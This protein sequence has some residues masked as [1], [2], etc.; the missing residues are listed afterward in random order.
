MESVYL[1]RYTYGKNA[2][3]AF[4]SIMHAYG[5]SCGVFYGEKAW[6]AAGKSVRDALHQAG[7]SIACSGLYGHEASMEN[8]ENIIRQCQESKP[9]FLIAAGGGKCVD[10]VKYAAEKLHLPLFTCPTIGSN[11]APVTKIAIM[12]HMD[13]SFREITQLSSPPVHCFINTEIICNA[14][15]EYLQAGIGDTMAK[16]V[17]AVFSARGD[18]LSYPVALGI[19]ISGLCWEGMLKDGYRAYEDARKHVLS[20]ELERV[21]QN[22]IITTGA[23]S[24]TVGKDYNSALAHALYYGLTVR[25]DVAEKYLHGAIVSYGTLIQLMLDHQMED[26]AKAWRFNQSM[27]LPVRLSDLGLSVDSD[28]SD[29]LHVTEINQEL[30]HVPYNID[31]HMILDAMKKLENWQPEEEEN[32]K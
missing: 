7:I 5:N 1:P 21:I 8:A 16:H 27:H 9:D 15:S 11:C 18:T 26:L 25:K 32:G 20:P 30:I 10:T 23:V 19:Q 12:Y 17:E 4:G 6:K 22:I 28:L 14:P 31:A 29:V 2:Y 13:G 3:D 24:V